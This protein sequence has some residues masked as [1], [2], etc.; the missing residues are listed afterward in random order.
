MEHTTSINTIARHI[1]ESRRILFITGAGISAD[2]G[3]PTYR[4]QGGM[5]N[6]NLTEDGIPVE[7]AL[8][9][10]MLKIDPSVS[11]KYLMRIEESC[12]HATFNRAHEVI[13][14]LE[15]HK[16]DTWVLTQN[17][18]GF[19]RQAGSHNLVEIHGRYTDLRCMDCD[20][21]QSVENYAHFT[22]FP[23]RCPQCH[24][25][26]LRPGVVL[27]GE[28]LPMGDIVTIQHQLRLG[29]DM[30]I[31]IGT[32]N[33]FPYITE[34]VLQVKRRGGVTVEINPQPTVLS[35]VVD[36]FLPL[37]A[38]EAMERIWRAVEPTL[39]G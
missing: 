37:G 17:I 4:G 23:P 35:D 18:D 28:T 1:S 21:K 25:G 27:Y 12:R 32:S 33:Q 16:P 26:I 38:A 29:F 6:D 11:W 30:V 15:Q 2:S 24:E 9:A 22:D 13:A 14:L 3:L 39:G 10:K 31:T 8:A 7:Q 20:F 19:H 34:P 36:H 5:Y